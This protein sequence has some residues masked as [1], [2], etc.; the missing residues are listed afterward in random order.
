ML[1][2]HT[3]ENPVEKSDEGA[4]NTALDKINGRFSC[5][6]VNNVSPDIDLIKGD[7][8]GWNCGSAACFSPEDN[9]A[10]KDI[11]S[12]DNG[13]LEGRREKTA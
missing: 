12:V 7:A 9:K 1:D 11:F 2:G 8:R 10:H 4:A 6:R 3:R 13:R 5:D